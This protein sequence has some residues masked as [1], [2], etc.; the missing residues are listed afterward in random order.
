MQ[1]HNQLLKFILNSGS[2]LLWRGENL[3][4]RYIVNL[5]SHSAMKADMERRLDKKIR[6]MLRKAPLWERVRM[7]SFPVG[8]LT[9]YLIRGFFD[10]HYG[11]QSMAEEE[12]DAQRD[13]RRSYLKFLEHYEAAGLL[14]CECSTQWQIM[15]RS[16]PASG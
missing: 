5:R 8:I 4:L 6:N 2:V 10:H 16:C 9:C 1:R 15:G 7:D 13:Q 14:S 11:K 12:W 3:A